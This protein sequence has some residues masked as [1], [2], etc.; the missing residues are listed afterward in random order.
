M[1]AGAFM[2]RT[3]VA[4]FR[5]GRSTGVLAMLTWAW[6][7]ADK[8]ADGALGKIARIAHEAGVYR[9]WKGM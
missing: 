9:A 6:P 7:L 2:D 1:K 5:D 4:P 8:T 3:S